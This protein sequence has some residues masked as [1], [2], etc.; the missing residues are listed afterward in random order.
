MKDFFAELFRSNLS[1]FQNITPV[2]KSGRHH[3]QREIMVQG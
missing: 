2:T 1:S 3:S